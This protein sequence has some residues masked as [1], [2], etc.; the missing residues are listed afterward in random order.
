MPERVLIIGNGG[1]EDAI[2]WK[3][4]QS[5]LIDHVETQPF[6]SVENSL[7]E[8]IQ[9]GITFVVVGPEGPLSQGIVDRFAQAKIP[10]FGPTKQ[11]A[12]LEWDK[13]WADGFMNRN[14]IP[15]PKSHTFSNVDE[16]LEYI[17]DQDPQ[18]L[19]IKASGLASGKGV[20]LPQTKAETELALAEMFQGKYGNQNT[21][22]IQER[23]TGRELS[24]ICLTDGTNIV[25]L[26][27]AQDHKRLKDNNKG[28]NTGGM[29][30]FVP[31]P[32]DVDL[33]QQIMETIVY[34][35]IKGLQEEG[36]KYT[37]AL[38]FGL[39]LTRDGPKVL[40]YNC[41][42]GDPETQPQILLLSSDLYP[43]LRACVDGNLTSSLVS[44]RQGASICVV[45][46]SEGYPQTPI[47][48]RIVQGLD[49]VT[50]P[51]V[52]VFHAATEEKD[53][54]TITTGGRVLG[55]T[56]YGSTLDEARERAYAKIG[57]QG[58]NF[59]GMQFRKDIGAS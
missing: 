22:V 3:L 58:V 49:T 41:R 5:S 15:H 52:I 25:P 26:L 30:A 51:N 24:L 59:E 35:T 18:S 7:N 37:G 55:I 31:T 40:E 8:A 39:M 4:N 48:K 2:R 47:I 46:A 33:E 32:L 1:R 23:L 14:N 6:S 27:P 53:G 34:P 54:K 28:P 43:A 42:F 36:I 16:A 19:V 56:A 21:V 20:I 29:G 17:Q 57:N 13:A 9:K 44:F 38:Y 11:A 50:D 10:A 45:L 12:R